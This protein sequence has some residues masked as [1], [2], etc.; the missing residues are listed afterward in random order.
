[1]NYTKDCAKCRWLISYNSHWSWV[2]SELHL[3]SGGWYKYGLDDKVLQ[4]KC[5]GCIRVY[6]HKVQV[7]LLTLLERFGCCSSFM[8]KDK[9]S[10]KIIPEELDPFYIFSLN[11]LGDK[12]I[13]KRKLE[14]F[15]EIRDSRG[16][17]E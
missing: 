14:R 13:A 12:L 17:K 1:M 2:W 6:A 16:E 4:G 10:R 7:W 15:I 11:T 8:E 5:T 9:I 3:G